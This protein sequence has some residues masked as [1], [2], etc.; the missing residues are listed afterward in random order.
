MTSKI[1]RSNRQHKTTVP[2]KPCSEVP[3]LHI[4]WTPPGMG[5]PP[6]PWAAWRGESGK[7]AQKGTRAA[8]TGRGAKCRTS[9]KQSSAAW[10]YLA[11]FHPEAWSVGGGRGGLFFSLRPRHTAGEDEGRGSHGSP[12]QQGGCDSRGRVAA[13]CHGGRPERAANTRGTVASL[14]SHG[15][16]KAGVC[17]SQGLRSHAKKAFLTGTFC[18]P[19]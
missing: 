8:Q 1:I 14:G 7:K 2:A 9:C 17:W 3:H 11:C 15:R 13:G 12:R 10:I 18:R 16:S 6:L 4:F 5:T 19:P